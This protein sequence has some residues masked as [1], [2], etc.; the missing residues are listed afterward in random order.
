MPGVSASFAALL[1]SPPDDDPARIVAIA[2]A[3]L[4]SENAS[5]LP[6]P[7]RE[8]FL[9]CAIDKAETI[10]AERLAARLASEPAHRVLARALSHGAARI[11][12]V[13]RVRILESLYA[14]DRREGRPADDYAVSARLEQALAALCASALSTEILERDDRP[15]AAL[16]AAVIDAAHGT[17]VASARLAADETARAAASIGFRHGFDEICGDSLGDMLEQNRK[18]EF[19]FAFAACAGVDPATARRALASVEALAIASAAAGL[20]RAAFARIAFTLHTEEETK[21][22]AVAVLDRYRAIPATK[23]RAVA[24]HW[25]RTRARPALARAECFSGADMAMAAG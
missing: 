3:A 9:R 5:L 23:A 21:I 11:S 2:E 15:D 22:H 10:I 14:L 19:I 13:R 18:A 24:D 12:A 6:A 7:H 25:V 16:L 17:A 8:V 1:S 4:P 20:S